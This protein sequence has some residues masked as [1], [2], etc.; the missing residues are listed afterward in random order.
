MLE[1]VERLDQLINHLLDAARLSDSVEE[2]DVELIDVPQLLTQ[3]V[4][5]VTLRYRVSRSI[6]HLDLQPLTVR[7]RPVDLSLVFRNLIDNA[8]K[9]AGV[10]P[11]VWI[12]VRQRG[13][14]G[15]VQVQDNGK[16]I[17]SGLRQKIFGR[18]FRVGEELERD[19]PGMGLGLYI[20]RT[21]TRRVRG[22]IRVRDRD[23]GPGTLFEVILPAEPV[24][25]PEPETQKA[26]VA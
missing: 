3:C 13:A 22:R 11:R 16:G 5:E 9:Y 18:F 7:A 26:D 23:G 20:V 14:E 25:A 6:V 15:V 1:D 8:V 21:L 24:R 17:P 10:E 12:T 19:T 4:D 2:R